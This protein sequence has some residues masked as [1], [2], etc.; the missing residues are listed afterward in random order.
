MIVLG[1]ADNHDSG[2]A[3][4][5]D[6]RLISAVNQERIDRV[7]QSGAFPWGAIDEALRVAG[8]VE[9]QVD[10]I[11]FGTNSPSGSA[12]NGVNGI[13]EV[14]FTDAEAALILGGNLK[15]IYGL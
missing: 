14:E 1:I 9:R 3:I 7:K 8:V 10:R 12:V 15:A 6:G 5:I 11:V 2:A 13:R 4:C